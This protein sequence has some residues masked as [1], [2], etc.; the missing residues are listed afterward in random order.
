M[1]KKDLT[2]YLGY[3]PGPEQKKEILSYMQKTGKTF[4]ESVA[5]FSMCPLVLRKCDGTFRLDGETYTLKT[6]HEKWPG[7]KI[8]ILS[9]PCPET[10][11][12]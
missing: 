9:K 5:D 12:N 2:T 4:I 3:D 7:R 8:V 11:I 6:F 10:T 1:N